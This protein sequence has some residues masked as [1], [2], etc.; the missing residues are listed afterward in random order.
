V[1]TG[2][3]SYEY[4]R[5]FQA[6]AR[7]FRVYALD[8]L[9]FGQSSHPSIVY[10][11]Q[12]YIRLL[13]DFARQVMGGA[14]NPVR[15]IASGLSAAFIIQAVGERSS[16]FEQ[17]V[18]VQPTG[19][20]TRHAAHTSLPWQIVR[21]VLSA[22]VVGEGLYN[23]VASRTSMR[24]MLA[25]QAYAPH[26]P[27]AEDVADHQYLAAHQRG[28]RFAAAS[29]LSGTLDTPVNGV[30]QELR[31]PI[32]LVWGKEA[33]VT[34]L[35]QARAFR[36]ANPNAEIRVL[37]GGGLPQDERPEEF[38]NEVSAWLRASSGSRRRP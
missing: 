33:R 37:D 28:A 8:L 19:L 12:M 2:A 17:L 6:L 29:F 15:V 18:L 13:Q 26:M 38:V 32:L 10:T 21:A 35:E 27:I 34:P 5:I 23:L 22:P 11:S 25:Q 31:Q 1:Y 14:D 7:D 16:L 36:Q 24:H 20:E 3:S 4:R 9:G 30:Y